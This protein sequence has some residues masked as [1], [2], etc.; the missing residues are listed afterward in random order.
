MIARPD[1]KYNLPAHIPQGT[2]NRQPLFGPSH[3]PLQP[4]LQLLP[5]AQHAFPE[6]ASQL[7]KLRLR[8]NAA[9]RL[10]LC[11]RFHRAEA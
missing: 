8:I 7:L 6:Q 3:Q 5:V 11:L 9:Y 1:S 4:L 2:V 10:F